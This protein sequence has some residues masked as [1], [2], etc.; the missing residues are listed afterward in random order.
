MQIEENH[1]VPREPP[2]KATIPAGSSP[3]D[4]GP[5]P[6]R[7]RPV[8]LDLRLDRPGPQRLL[9]DHDHVQQR[10]STHRRDPRS[11]V[12]HHPRRHVRHHGQQRHQQQQLQGATDL[13]GERAHLARRLVHDH[14]PGRTDGHRFEAAA[15]VPVQQQQVGDAVAQ[16]HPLPLRTTVGWLCQDH[17]DPLSGRIAGQRLRR[18]PGPEQRDQRPVVDLVPRRRQDTVRL[19]L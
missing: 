12:P 2:R 6:D 5:R 17:H 1:E 8:R 7:L 3:H 16:R 18:Q 14:R 4:R 15:G 13:A 19:P 10:R 9:G 11:V